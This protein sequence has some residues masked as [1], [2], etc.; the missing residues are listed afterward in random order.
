MLFFDFFVLCGKKI[1]KKISRNGTTVQRFFPFIV[2][3]D[4]MQLKTTWIVCHYGTNK[5]T[6]LR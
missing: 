2:C 1:F 4:W 3:G 6:L 5:V